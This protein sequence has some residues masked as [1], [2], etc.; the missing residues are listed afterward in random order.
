MTRLSSLTFRLLSV[1]GLITSVAADVVPEAFYTQDFDRFPDGT[2]ELGDGSVFGGDAIIVDGQLRLSTNDNFIRSSFWIPPFA[3]SVNG[4]V[5]EFDYS[6]FENSGSDPADGFSFSYGNIPEGTISERAEEGFPGLAPVLS[7]EVDTWMV[8][9]PEVGPAIAVNDVTIPGGS[10]NGPILLGGQSIQGA[11]RISMDPEGT[12]SFTSTGA[13]TN[14]AFENLPSSFEPNQDF[15]FVLAART[16]GAS[17]EVRIDNLR[18]FAGVEPSDTIAPISSAAHD[19]ETMT[20]QIEIPTSQG[21]KIGI[22]FSPDLTPGSWI[23]LGNF[24]RVDNC[25]SRFTD[26]DLARTSGGR[27]F[28]RAFLRPL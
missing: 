14:A 6:I 10:I 2:T 1:F 24:S 20:V 7:F 22:E 23:E 19:E 4:W 15:A 9:D 25:T 12:V 3:D 13:L 21:R 28:Y 26:S 5:A 27:G 18:I 11:I 17:Q 16:G 8:G